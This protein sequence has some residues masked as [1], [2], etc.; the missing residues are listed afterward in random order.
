MNVTTEN[1]F[2]NFTW[3]SKLYLNS[4]VVIK[5]LSYLTKY[6]KKEFPLDEIFQFTEYL[7]NQFN[8][9]LY[10]EIKT[11]LKELTDLREEIKTG[12]IQPKR[13]EHVIKYVVN[14][15]LWHFTGEGL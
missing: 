15:V 12:S 14:T 13:D 6:S 8:Q 11:Q 7:N 2:E 4:Q 10:P 9:E 1:Q 3:R 5:L